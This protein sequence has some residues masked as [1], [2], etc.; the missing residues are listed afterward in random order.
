MKKLWFLLLLLTG[1]MCAQAVRYDGNVFTSATNVP[2]GAQAQ[3]YTLPFAKISICSYPASGGPCTNFAPIFADQGMTMQLSPPLVA[4]A[5]GR[6][7]FWTTAGMYSYSVVTAGG[8][9]VGTFILTLGGGGSSNTTYVQGISPIS[10]T[11]NGTIGTPYIISQITGFAITSFSGCVGTVELGTS[12][13]NPNFTAAYT[14]IPATATITNTEGIGSPLALS[15]PFTSGT[16]SGTFVHTS[17]ETT[18]FTLNA[19]QGTSQTASCSDSWKPAVFGGVG[20]TGASSTVT[21]S[22]TIAILSTGDHL[23]RVQLGAETVGQTFGP[24]SPSSQV[25][26]LLLTG[27]SHTFVDANTGFPFAFNAP[28]PV[29]FVNAQGT[30]VT[31]FLYASTNPLFGSYAPKVTS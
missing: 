24:Y 12:I 20:A 28:V 5:Q 11:G 9:Y 8:T 7:G 22:G 21:S 27:G 2:Y 13:A 10:V 6:Y 26:Y 31:M 16:V 19:S 4:D 14:T 1:T 29:S 18:T 3:M 17:T 23:A 15:S 25:I 30:T